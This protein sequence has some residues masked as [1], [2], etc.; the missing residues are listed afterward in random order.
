MEWL[1][2]VLFFVGSGGAISLLYT[3]HRDTNLRVLVRLVALVCGFFVIATYSSIYGTPAFDVWIHLSM[4]LVCMFC[5]F[6]VF[7]WERPT[8]RSMVLA[9]WMARI[10]AV[11]LT[12]GIVLKAVPHLL[13]SF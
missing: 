11:L 6:I 10:S 3:K 5:G 9:L 4:I 8:T 1:Y 12:L 2:L 7:S 13:E